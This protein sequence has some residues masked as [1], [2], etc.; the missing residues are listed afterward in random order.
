[1]LMRYMLKI[2]T[3]SLVSPFTPEKPPS[4]RVAIVVPLSTRGELSDDE[5]TSM[6]HLLHHLGAYDKYLIAPEGL[7]AHFPG[8][9]L[10]HFARKYFGS[11]A[12]HGKMLGTPA[13]YRQF[14]D[15]EFIF[16]YHLDS[17]AFSDQMAAWCATDLDYIGPPWIHCAA[18]P[19]AE[20][21]R[22]GNGGFTLL[23]VAS[24]LKVLANRYRQEPSSYWLDQFTHCAPVWLVRSLER[25]Q[26]R[27]PNAEPLN[28]L[29]KEWHAMEDPGSHYRNNDM[30]WSDKAVRYVPE[31]KVASLEQGLRF[32]FEAAPRT[33]FEMNGGRMPFGCHA[34]ARYDREFW[35]PHL[36]RDEV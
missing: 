3:R 22:V 6:R 8:F 29:L 9:E 20:R 15:Y 10:K 17:L 26:N 21:P 1:M 7:E 19:W 18:T 14:L 34:W 28:R 12:A 13:F 27:F 23:R 24:A 16:F 4:K 36:L 35:A 25:I 11:A 5:R 31:F 32:A 30:F 2:L 33:C